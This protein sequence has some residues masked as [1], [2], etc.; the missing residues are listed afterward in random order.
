MPLRINH[1]PLRGPMNMKTF[2]ALLVAGSL[3]SLSYTAVYA[4]DYIAQPN[5]TLGTLGSYDGITFYFN[6]KQ[7]FPNNVTCGSSLI[8]CLASNVE[9]KNRLAVALTA[10][11]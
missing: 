9:C 5:V 11:A 10:K 6:L 8:Y 7:G 1:L 3:M 2:T 4:D